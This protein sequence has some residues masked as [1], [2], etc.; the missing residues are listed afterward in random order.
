MTA[1][2]TRLSITTFVVLVAATIAAFF[3]T[4]H[5]KVTTPLVQ[6][7]PFPVPGVIDPLHPVRCGKF[8]TGSTTVSF[9]LQHRSDNVDVDV[10]AGTGSSGAIVRQ[11]A[12]DR[13][14]RKDVRT[15][16]G[17]FHWD[18]RLPDGGV[19][20]DGT[21]HFR[22]VLLH[23]DRAVDLTGVPVKVKTVP[24]HPV[25]TSVSPSVISSSGAARVVIRY[26]GNENRGGTILLYRL[27]LPGG[28]RL[29]K[30]FPTPWRGES[31]V[32]DGTVR[33]HRP[34][35]PGTYLIAL[36]VSDAACNTGRYPARLPPA[37]TSGA[38]DIV[39]VG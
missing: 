26:A 6:G 8:N 36:T 12:T 30:K 16:D 28:P 3:V 21:Y 25:I 22:V 5:L 33:G 15:P 35:P 18:G 17:V 4:Q 24:P 10:V 19:A 29:V 7:S 37:P 1:T 2:T 20:P 11:V 31:A 34:A 38:R 32:W 27:G 9:Y 23:Q 39:T 14:M 13:H